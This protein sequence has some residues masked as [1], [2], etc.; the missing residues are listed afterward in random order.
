MTAAPIPEPAPRSLRLLTLLEAAELLHMH[1]EELRARA[2]LGR[3]PG[4]KTGRRW[5]FIEEDLL[6][7]VR[8]LYP[9]QRQALQVTSGKEHLCH[10]ASED[11]S[12]G[13]TS[14]R[15]QASAYDDLLRPATRPRRRNCTTS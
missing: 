5:V 3:V 15:P 6:G 1:P 14:P 8:S 7:W 4:A 11:R 10:F 2:K 12:G 9:V 13:S